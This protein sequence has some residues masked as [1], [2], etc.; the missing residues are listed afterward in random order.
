MNRRAQAMLKAALSVAVAGLAA[1]AE[2]FYDQDGV[3]FE[4]TIRLVT[5]EAGVCNVLQD[6]YPEQVYEKLKANQGRPLD[7]WRVDF[8]I[9]NGSGR[10][11]DYLNAHS[12]VRAE[13][14]PCTNWSGPERAP[15]EPFVPVEWGD[16]LEGLQERRVQSA[17]RSTSDVESD[18]LQTYSGPSER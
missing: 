1:Q 17:L 10:A 3:K 7:L 11:L 14:P 5:S 13:H 4:G 6:H 9:H 18:I 12:W 8:L 16:Y 2:T 15:L